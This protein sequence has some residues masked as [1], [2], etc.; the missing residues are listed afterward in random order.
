MEVKFGNREAAILVI[1][2]TALFSFMLFGFT[3][4]KVMMGFILL[5][6]LP[7]YLILDNF[8][9]EMG[10]KVI[11][12]FFIGVVMFPALVYLLGLLISVKLS[13]LIVFVFLIAVGIL[14]KR[15]MRIKPIINENK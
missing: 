11:F 4:F 1:A 8:D 6:F 3:G 7:F 5:F 14:I 9:L 15:L 13:I 12:S 2:L 10:E